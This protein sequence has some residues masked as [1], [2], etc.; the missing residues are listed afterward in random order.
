[1]NV[2]LA[3]ANVPYEQ[4][5]DLELNSEMDQCDVALIIGANDVVNPD[6][7]GRTARSPACRSLTWTR[8][9]R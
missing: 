1:M 4:L 7:R 6:A 8:L 5:S 3:E 9:V 2:L